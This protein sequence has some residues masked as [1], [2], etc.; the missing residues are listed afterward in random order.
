MGGEK[1]GGLFGRI[2]RSR[3]NCPEL[4]GEGINKGCDG[5][6][7]RQACLSLHPFPAYNHCMPNLLKVTLSWQW[8]NQYDD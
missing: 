3:P 6:T 1:R 5:Q 4:K 7:L 8:L 2:Q